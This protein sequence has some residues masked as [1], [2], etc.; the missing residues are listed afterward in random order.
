MSGL[1]GRS[2]TAETVKEAAGAVMLRSKPGTK[3]TTASAY[4][5]FLGAVAGEAATAP[6]RPATSALQEDSNSDEDEVVL[7]PVATQSAR[8]APPARMSEEQERRNA[9]SVR[10]AWLEQQEAGAVLR[11]EAGSTTTSTSRKVAAHAGKAVAAQTPAELRFIA[12]ASFQGAKEGYVFKRGAEGTGYY[13]DLPS[14]AHG[15]ADDDDAIAIAAALQSTTPRSVPMPHGLPS[16]AQDPEAAWAAVPSG[17][18]ETTPVDISEGP[19]AVESGSGAAAA[20]AA[21]AAASVRPPLPRVLAVAQAQAPTRRGPPVPGRTAQL[22]ARDPGLGVPGVEGSV[23]GH[24]CG[25]GGES[26]HPRGASVVEFGSMMAALDSSSDE[27]EDEGEGEDEDE[28][29]VAARPP[30]DANGP[31]A[32]HRAGRAAVKSRSIGAYDSDD[33]EIEYG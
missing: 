2:A 24:T 20:A 5:Q 9:I 4:A 14:L 29:E 3:K 22:A 23:A 25:G 21:E 33:G 18:S 7:A 15:G 31:E 30:D 27:E 1:V 8:P 17:D 10:R 28:G 16:F 32:S 11:E 13:P 12:A 26:S 19:S 6:V